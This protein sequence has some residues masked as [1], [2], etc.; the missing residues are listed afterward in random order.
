MSVESPAPGSVTMFTTSWCGYCRRLKAQMDREGVAYSEVNIEET[1]D[2]A[3]F[4]MT[5]N[6][7]NQ[8]VPTLLFPDGSVATNPSINEVK[9]R[10][11]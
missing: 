4:V 5:V 11:V 3:D 6:G 8:T 10:L 2:A 9:K 7:G 1:P